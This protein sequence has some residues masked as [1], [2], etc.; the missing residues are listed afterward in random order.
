MYTLNTKSCY[1]GLSM[2]QIATILLLLLIGQN[3]IAGDN[4]EFR[5]TWVITWELIS[6][7][8]TVEQNKAQARQILDNHQKANMNAVLWQVRQGGTAYYNSSF[9]PWGYYAGYSNPGY[10]PLAYAI[11][12]AH[13]RG[14]EVHAWFNVFQTSSTVSGAPAAKHPEWICRDRD[15]YPMTSS[16]CLSPGLEAVREYTINVA[17]EIV[18][19]YD[20]DGLH[21][22]YVRWNEYS[23]SGFSKNLAKAAERQPLLDGMITEAQIHDLEENFAGRYLYDIEHP[24][25]AGVP[26][27]FSSWEDWWRWSVT[28]F[29]RV[30]NDSIKNVK[31][32]VRLTPAALGKY[33]WSGW[34]GYGTVYQDAALWFN[35]GYVDQLTPMHYH[36][37][38]GDGFY[39]M[40]AGNTSESWG[41]YIQQGINAGRLFS[42]GPGSYI[43]AE[44]KIW[45]RHPEV[46]AKVRTVPWVDGFQFFSYGSWKGYEYWD[47]AGATFFDRKTKIRPTKLIHAIAPDAPTIAVQK[48]DSLNYQITVTPPAS[49]NVNQRYAIYRSPD[50]DFD[51]DQDEI[52]DIHFGNQSY[53]FIDNFTGQQDYNETYFYGA[54]TLDRYWNESAISNSNESDPIPSFPPAVIATVPAEGDTVPVN[55]PLIFTFSKTMDISSVAGAI[56]ISPP[57]EINQLI[58]K[59]GN[60]SLSIDVK[61]NFAFATNYTVTIGALAQDI[62]GRSI[63]GNGDGIAGDPFVLNFTTREVDNTGPAIIA[64]YPDFENQIEPF[65]VDDVITLLFDELI[66]PQSV[67]DTTVILSLNGEQIKTQAMVT[68]IA[69]RSLINLKGF[70]PLLQD[71][72]YSLFLHNTIADTVGNAMESSLEFSF[73]TASE[74]YIETILIDNFSMPGPWE[75]PGYSG[76][77][78][79]IVVSGTSFGYSKD[80]YLPGSATAPVHKRSAYIAYQWTETPPPAGYLLREYLSGGAPRDVQFD[81]THILQCYVYGDGSN[82]KFRFSLR[83]IEG[84]GYPLEVSKWV[85]IDWYGWKLLEWDLS[86]PNSVGTWL[87]NEIMDGKSYFVD[88][89]QLTH[90]NTGAMSGIIYVDNLRV[91][92]KSAEPVSVAEKTPPIIAS[93]RLLQNYPNPFNPTTSIPFDLPKRGRVVLKVYDMLG[94]KIDTLLDENLPAGRHQI[95]FDGSQLPS[96]IYFYRIE[97]EGQIKNR[98][99]VMVK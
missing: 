38:T 28:E 48:I 75:Q 16:I 86:D 40:L 83:E 43:F 7:G 50:A 42:T 37:T 68:A 23:N 77:T 74:Y 70:A 82:N 21:L 20:I 89:F 24:Y 29:V 90:D 4:E 81:A 56:L 88:S 99:M 63:D 54:T 71:A 80:I 98:Q 19:K 69:D 44:Q 32:W 39:S 6:A 35:E 14:M 78:A 3:L 30:L 91:V 47:E 9:E 97:F 27:G 93:F 87:G 41:M 26:Q 96:G 73:R 95:Q 59:D 8:K 33:N 52:I 55:T 84:Q 13:K 94:R 45:H 5:A 92:K 31:P 62:N 65:D 60:K 64:T 1:G 18:R 2:K 49:I 25:S 72:D 11:E 61:G 58:W 34:Q 36:W 12:E 10:D 79:G 66:D 53:S 15:G 17:M 51:L 22:D 46:V 57:I 67:K 76:S 85:T